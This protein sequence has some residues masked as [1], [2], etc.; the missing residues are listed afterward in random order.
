MTT[1]TTNPI[2]SS[3]PQDL[4]FNAALLDQVV[5]GPA[6]SVADRLGASRMTV[7]GAIDT[8][9][10]FN[11]R[12]AWTAGTAYALKDLVANSGVTYA[13]VLAHTS[14]TFAT[15]LAAGWWVVHQGV[16]G[17]DLASTG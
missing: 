4:L 14:G 7:Q 9:K 11:A 3:A 1:P 13:A 8:I 10:A 16:V 15:D 17:V 12:G 2:P 5:N 6:P